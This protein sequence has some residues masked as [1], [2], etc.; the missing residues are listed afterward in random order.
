MEFVSPKPGSSLTYQNDLELTFIIER[1]IKAI[2]SVV[3]NHHTH[4]T[5]STFAILR[6][7]AKVSSTKVVDE[8][9]LLLDGATYFAF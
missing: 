1:R 9:D 4:L 8:L 7:K 2:C 5:A 6:L 3:K